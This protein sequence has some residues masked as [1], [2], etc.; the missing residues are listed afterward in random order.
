MPRRIDQVTI[1][2]SRAS[3]IIPWDSREQLLDRIRHDPAAEPVTKAFQGAGTTASV[4]L[5]PAGRTLILATIEQW[6]DDATLAEL[7]DGLY[8]LR[9]ELRNDVN[10]A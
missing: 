9:S 10:A 4:Q 2:L 5:D 3:V 7:P 1:E 8:D 6:I